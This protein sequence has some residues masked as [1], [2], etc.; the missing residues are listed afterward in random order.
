MWPQD[1]LHRAPVNDFPPL[2]ASSW[3]DDKY[4][5]WADLTITSNGITCTQKMRWIERSQEAGFLMGSPK[6]ERESINDNDMK[7]WANQSESDPINVQ[8][9]S[10]FWLANTPCTQNFWVA[11]VGSNP[12]HFKNLP[13]SANL[14]V[15]NIAFHDIGNK[16]ASITF[17]LEVLNQLVGNVVGDAPF[18]NSE[19]SLLYENDDLPFYGSTF[20]INLPTE[21]EW[22]Y[23]CRADTQTA[24]WWG[25]IFD[26]TFAN[27]DYEKNQDFN[28][29]EGTN[30]VN[31]YIPNPW[32]LYDMHGNVWEWTSSVWKPNLGDKNGKKD[33]SRMVLKGGCWRVH[34][35]HARSADRSYGYLDNIF[36]FQGFRFLIKNLQSFK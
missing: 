1:Q 36:P 24:Y 30:E 35:N 17:F 16:E 7:A 20:D 11:V 15:E 34:P 9:K 4:G 29:F 10:G 28:S 26:A 14:P 33:E 23:A 8:L 19:N 5:I 22:E 3:G 25:D 18:Y 32:G 21:L 13:Q 31:F 2:W 27:T 6:S 12:S